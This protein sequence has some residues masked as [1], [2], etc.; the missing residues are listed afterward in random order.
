MYDIYVYTLGTK[1]E[2]VDYAIY[3]RDRF[4]ISAKEAWNMVYSI[5]TTLVRRVD[6]SIARQIKSD[7]E[8]KGAVVELRIVR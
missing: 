3:I 1:V 4:N 5:P 6:E 8:K 7:L 2:K